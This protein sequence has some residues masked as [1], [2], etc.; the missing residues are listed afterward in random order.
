MK[1]SAWSKTIEKYLEERR[2]VSGGSPYQPIVPT[3]LALNAANDTSA[4][5]FTDLRLGVAVNAGGL[6]IGDYFDLT[7]PEANDLSYQT[8]GVLYAGRY[9]RV[10]VDSG[11]TAA[12]VKTGTIGLMPSLAVVS[13]NKYGTRNPPMNVVTSYDQG[14]G[15]STNVRP[16]VFLNSITPGNYGFVQELGVATVLGAAS[17]TGTP[18]IGVVLNSVASGLVDV[19]S[20]TTAVVKTTIGTA[21]DLPKASALFRALLQYVPV[22]QG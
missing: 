8:N 16:V 7:N 21:I 6:N 3:W 11:A 18:A 14:I 13:L 5:Y 19:P 22:V 9:R 4:S 12:N 10:Q 2:P 20:A 1:L 17:L 15:L